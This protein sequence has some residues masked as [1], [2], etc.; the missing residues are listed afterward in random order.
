MKKIVSFSVYGDNPRYIIGCK[1]QCELIQEMLP[2]WTPYIYTDHPENFTDCNAVTFPAPSNHAGMFWRFLP[3][4]ESDAW[5]LTRD[6]DSRFTVREVRA[7]REWEQSKCSLHI[8]RDH[9]WHHNKP[10]MGGLTGIKGCLPDR[11]KHKLWELITD[12]HQTQYAR[13]EEFLRDWVWPIFLD[14][15]ITHDSSQ[16]GWFADTRKRLKTPTDFCGNGYTEDDFALYPASAA[17]QL[18]PQS[19][20]FDRGVLNPP[21]IQIFLFNWPGQ[22]ERA[23]TTERQLWNLGH[24]VIV[25]N[26]DPGYTPFNWINLGNDAWFSKQWKLATDLFNADIMFHIQADATYDKWKPVLDDAVKYF[27]RYHYGIYGPG[28]VDNGYYVPLETWQSQ[29][30][31]IYA[32]PNPDCTCW[33][34]HRD[35]IDQFRSLH[36]DLTQNHYGWGIDC[37]VCAVSWMMGRIVLRDLNHNIMHH[38]GRGY[39]NQDA[40]DQMNKMFDT[41]NPSL[42][43][44]IDRQYQNR[45]SL[46]QY[47]KS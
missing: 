3:F 12:P 45:E 27:D 26:S 22:T 29:D 33:F 31:G 19:A 11:I 24:N 41:L 6:A 39:S 20:K 23:K 42:R 9:D 21:K 4:W 2:D 18:T 14:D 16:P 5:C 17:Q 8:I 1:R 35:V 38:P 28:F 40:T 15:A 37:V 46:L 10:M 13:D 44:A 47:L 36:L 7:I 34:I 25:I 32:I 43:Q 30:P